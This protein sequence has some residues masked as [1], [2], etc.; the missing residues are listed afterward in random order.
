VRRAVLPAALLALL[1]VPGCGTEP[2]ADASGE[3]STLTVLAA[4]S[5]TEVFTDLGEEFEADHPGIEVRFAFDSSATLAQQAAEGAPADVLATADLESMQAAKAAGVVAGASRVFATNT[6]VMVTPPDDPAGLS[7][8]TDLNGKD[9][10]YVVCVDTAPCGKVAATLLGAADITT[11]PASFEPDVKAVL[12]RVAEGEA[13]AGVVYATDAV[14]AGDGVRSVEIPG[15]DKAVTTYPLAGLTQSKDAD[16]AAEF[17]ELIVG[18]QGRSAL[19]DA[20][21]G[22]PS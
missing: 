22:P 7:T 13:D 11:E 4:S 6:A 19:A 18:D 9:I 10:R 21:F 8:F 16:L 17:V 20:G 15:A 2:D 1:P 12:A 5:L 3:A 14:A